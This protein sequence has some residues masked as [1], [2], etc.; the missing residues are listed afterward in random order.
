MLRIFLGDDNDRVG[1]HAL[2]HHS[3]ASSSRGVCS[4]VVDGQLAV[5]KTAE[6]KPDLVIPD[7]SA[8]PCHSRFARRCGP[9]TWFFFVS[10]SAEKLRE[11]AKD[12]VS[13]WLGASSAPV[14]LRQRHPS[15]NEGLREVTA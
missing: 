7:L 15:R 13:F 5:E 10:N 8:L 11:A 2:Q 9:S 12:G 14:P 6:L 4:E 1:P 3:Q